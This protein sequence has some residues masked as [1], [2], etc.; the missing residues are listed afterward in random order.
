MP[1]QTPG[2]ENEQVDLQQEED[3]EGGRGRRGEGW[4]GK[5]EGVGKGEGR[6]GKREGVGKGEG[7]ERGGEGRE[8][9]ERRV[10]LL[11]L[12]SECQPITHTAVPSEWV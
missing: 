8:G 12:C 5:R 1:S 4:G 2:C 6:G 7:R 11:V 3:G 9:I 10:G